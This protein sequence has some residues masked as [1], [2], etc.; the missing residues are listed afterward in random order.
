M[1]VVSLIVALIIDMIELLAIMIEMA[2]IVPVEL[3]AL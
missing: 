2:K 1:E 3:T